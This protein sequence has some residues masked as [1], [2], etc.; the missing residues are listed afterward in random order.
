LVYKEFGGL[1]FSLGG[2]DLLFNLFNLG[3]IPFW[4]N[5]GLFKAQTL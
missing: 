3:I 5:K 1:L 2:G 4:G